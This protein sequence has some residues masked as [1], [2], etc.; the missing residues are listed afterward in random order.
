MDEVERKAKDRR[1]RKKKQRKAPGTRD[2]SQAPV[3]TGQLRAAFHGRLS[4]VFRAGSSSPPAPF[5]RRRREAAHER[6]PEK[7]KE[8]NASSPFA[9]SESEMPRWA[10]TPTK[11]AARCGETGESQGETRTT[12]RQVHTGFCMRAGGRTREALK[13]RSGMRALGDRR[14]RSV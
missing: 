10:G 13:T 8:E 9:P 1:R 5:N 14:T 4:S 11:S 12:R 6:G 2:R 3:P 7:K